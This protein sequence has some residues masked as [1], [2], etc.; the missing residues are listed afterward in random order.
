MKRKLYLYHPAHP[1]GNY[2]TIPL[3]KAPSGPAVLSFACGE[4]V[5]GAISIECVHMSSFGLSSFEVSFIR[6]S[7]SLYSQFP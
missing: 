4:V 1:I 3:S 7:N 5:R 6:G 2:Y